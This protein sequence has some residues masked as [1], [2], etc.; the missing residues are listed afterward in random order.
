MM[1]REIEDKSVSRD[2]PLIASF[3]KYHMLKRYTRVYHSFVRCHYLGSESP[4]ATNDEFE[5]SLSNGPCVAPAPPTRNVAVRQHGLYIILHSRSP[6]FLLISFHS[7]SRF[8]S[9]ITEK[10]KSYAN[11]SSLTSIFTIHQHYNKSSPLEAM[12]MMMVLPKINKETTTTT[13]TTTTTSISPSMLLSK[14]NVHSIVASILLL[15]CLNLYLNIADFDRGRRE[16]RISVSSSGGGGVILHSY[17][18]PSQLNDGSIL[19][20]DKKVI[21]NTQSASAPA[22]VSSIS[23][24]RNNKNN[25]N[26]KPTLVLHMGPTKTGSTFTQCVLTSMQETLA[27]D[28]YTYLGMGINPCLPKES[29]DDD[30]VQQQQREH[31]LMQHCYTSMFIYN[32]G[33]AK[34][35]PEALTIFRRAREMQPR[36][37]AIFVN[38]CFEFYTPDQIKVLAA[39]LRPHWNV[40]IILNYR[41]IYEFLPSSYNQNLK[42]KSHVK[43]TWWFDAKRKKNGAKK[44][45]Q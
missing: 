11:L 7:F 25:N 18:V 32:T 35:A 2:P 45:I 1:L 20:Q 19:R 13:T 5:F 9:R 43:G 44:K 4:N 41:R 15:F 8:H 24:L 17:D 21:I 27:L 37:N 38:E 30:N 42:P 28:N 10:R 12:K 39:E 22:V 6:H 40:K 14:V 33:M 3:N 36:Q 26:G 31:P 23:T 29:S 34:L 16:T